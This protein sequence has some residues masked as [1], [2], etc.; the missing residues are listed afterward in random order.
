MKRTLRIVEVGRDLTFSFKSDG[1]LRA[2]YVRWASSTTWRFRSF[3]GP[4][5][6]QVFNGQERR[7]WMER[8]GV[9]VKVGDF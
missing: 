5:L 1:Q 6:V 3:D 7:V 2:A 8:N 4:V 9:A